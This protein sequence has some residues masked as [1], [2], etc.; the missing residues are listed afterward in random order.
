LAIGIKTT[1]QIETLPSK[2]VEV[3]TPIS[4]AKVVE[5]LVE[6]GASVKAELDNSG[7]QLKPGMFAELEVLTDRTATAILAILSSAVV[8]ANGRKLVYVQR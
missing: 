3:T 1:G 6:P 4:G 2:K 7:S 8:E 5:L